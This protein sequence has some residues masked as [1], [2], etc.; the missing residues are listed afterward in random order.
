MKKYILFFSLLFVLTSTISAQAD[1][2]PK[3]IIFRTRLYLKADGYRIGYLRYITDSSIFI[4]KNKLPLIVNEPSGEQG[5]TIAYSN[6]SR[7][8][9]RREGTM[10]TGA[11]IGAVAG[12]ATGAFVAYL[13]TPESAPFQ[14][15]TPVY[16]RHD[17]YGIGVLAG[18]LSGAIVGGL[19]GTLIYR[20]FNIDGKRK[21][22]TDLKS[23]LFDKIIYK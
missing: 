18:G 8:Q 19:I 23:K 5:L 1:L 7:L 22:V 9:L 2:P 12:G 11:I 20:T 13:N 21:R 16:N 15:G 6:L 14:F 10:V 17:H 3:Q 4:S